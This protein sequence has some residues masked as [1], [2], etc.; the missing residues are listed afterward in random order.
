MYERFVCLSMIEAYMI[1]QS[2]ERVTGI[3]MDFIFILK[4]L[5]NSKKIYN[6]MHAH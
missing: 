3:L 4:T 2:I 5:S 1:T 6:N